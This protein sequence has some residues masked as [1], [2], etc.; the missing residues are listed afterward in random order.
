MVSGENNAIFAFEELEYSYRKGW[1]RVNEESWQQHILTAEVEMEK[2]WVAVRS[3][4][5]F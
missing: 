5:K 3:D 1:L 2:P 4:A